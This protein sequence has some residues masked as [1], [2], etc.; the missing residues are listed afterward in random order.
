[1]IVG[2][3]FDNTLVGYDELMWDIA[4]ARGFVADDVPPTKRA[5]RDHIRRRPDG[6][7]DWQH[8]QAA[9][10]GPRIKDARLMDGVPAFFAAA[11]AARVRACVVSH[12]T[13]R[14]S[15]DPAIDLRAAAA[16]WMVDQGF[17]S[18]DGFGL[19]EE[20]VFFESTRAAKV[21]RVAALGC[22]H[23][24]DDLEETFADAGFPASVER[25]LFAPDGAGIALPGV[26]V[27]RSWPE[28]TRRVFA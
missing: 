5:I 14:S 7:L 8:V 28:I 11:R 13:A 18:P 15:V 1:M 4:R 26:A 6:D 22:T 24:I 25:I 20:D 17:F 10:Y 3:D 2:V 21:A 16:R 23:F 19:R 9:A 27:C 12:K